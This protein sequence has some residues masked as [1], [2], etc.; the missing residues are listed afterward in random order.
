MHEQYGWLSCGWIGSTSLLMNH[1]GPIV[2]INP[3]ELHI[4]DPE[5]I[6]TLYSGPSKIRDK[7]RW[8]A[9]MIA[10]KPTPHRISKLRDSDLA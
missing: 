4:N 1:S 9:R 3:H 8:M 10:C 5:Y 6:D 7:Y 2:R